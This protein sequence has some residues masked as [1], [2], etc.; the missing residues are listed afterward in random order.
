MNNEYYWHLVTLAGSII[1]SISFA[2]FSNP[3]IFSINT[4][5]KFHP[6]QQVLCKICY[7]RILR[8]ARAES[9][10]VPECEYSC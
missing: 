2:N 10:I 5:S 4:L 1:E 9:R 7:V 8:P 6:K 3:K